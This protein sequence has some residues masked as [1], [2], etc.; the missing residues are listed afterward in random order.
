MR[1]P[2]QAC[3]NG[4]SW[5]FNLCKCVCFNEGCRLTGS[6][7]STGNTGSTGSTGSTNS[8]STGQNT[9]IIV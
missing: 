7:G 6:T 9:E 2:Q 8:G 3:Q 1:C 4:Y 5:D